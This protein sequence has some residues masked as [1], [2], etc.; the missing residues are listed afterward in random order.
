MGIVGAV[1]TIY[2]SKKIITVSRLYPF[3]CPE[4]ASH[5]VPG[6]VPAPVQSLECGVE[7]VH[8]NVLHFW[9]FREAL[10]TIKIGSCM[11][12]I[13]SASVLGKFPLVPQK[14]LQS[15]GA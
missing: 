6:Q 11:W 5:W 4:W 12:E 14:M 15:L 10:L 3:E 1:A 2:F 8:E 9:A 13:C 7:I